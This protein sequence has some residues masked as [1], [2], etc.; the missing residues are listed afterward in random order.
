M[1]SEDQRLRAGLTDDEIAA[2]ARLLDRLQH[3][4]T[5]DASHPAMCTPAGVDTPPH[6]R[7][8]T[9]HGS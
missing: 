1:S 6:Q 2:L 5:N 9:Q 7:P 8:Q 4:V 3:N